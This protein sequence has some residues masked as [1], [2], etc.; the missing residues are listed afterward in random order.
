MSE[1]EEYAALRKAFRTDMRHQALP[2]A[3]L[4][5]LLPACVA[6]GPSPGTSQ[7][8][9]A[10]G[11]LLVRPAGTSDSDG[12][13]V[14]P[15][16][17]TGRLARPGL[18]EGSGPR[19]QD[20]DRR[21]P[22]VVTPYLE[23]GV[24]LEITGD[25]VRI[26]FDQPMARPG[27]IP[28]KSQDAKGTEPAAKGAK[29]AAAP[30]GRVAAPPGTLTIT[31]AV[32]GRVEWVDAYT[33]EFVAEEPMKIGER[34]EIALG[35][36]RSLA[37]GVPAAAWRT[38]AIPRAVVAGKILGYAPKAGAP[39]VV[40]MH[41]TG[42][43]V[44][45]RPEIAVLY[46]QP[47]DLVRAQSLVRIEGANGSRVPMML[48]RPPGPT[49]QGVPVDPRFVVVA[50][51]PPL[52]RGKT[53]SLRSMPAFEG[54]RGASTAFEIAP[55]L[56]VTS[57]ECP[58]ASDD[59]SVD[60][61]TVSTDGNGVDFDINNATP[62]T[63]KSEDLVKLVKVSPRVDHL[64]VYGGWWDGSAI[65]VRGAFEPSKRYEIT[66][67]GLV[68]RYGSR[69]AAP[70]RATLEKAPRDASVTMAS[71]VLLLDE[72]RTKR[73]E[74]TT[75]N[76]ELVE[77]AFWP[78][79]DEKLAAAVRSVQVGTRPLEAPHL[80]L[81]VTIA[82]R[83][84]E[85][86]TTPVDLSA[87]LDPG[88]RYIAAVRVMQ[89]LG[90]ADLPGKDERSPLALIVPG[91]AESLAVHVEK[92][93]ARTLVHVARLA[94][95]EAV[96]GAGIALLDAS[97]AD[98]STFA[99][100][101]DGLA[102]LPADASGWLAVTSGKARTLLHLGNADT[103]AR[104]LFPHLA[105][106]DEIAAGAPRGVLF[107]DRGIYR[108]GATVNLFASVRKPES[109]ALAPFADQR[110][111]AIAL[112][113]SGEEVFRAPLTTNDLGS[114]SASFALS[115]T[116]KL[117]RHRVVL[118][119][120]G[121]ERLADTIVQVAE[122][123]PPRFAVDVNTAGT[124]ARALRASVLARYLFGAPMSGATVKWTARREAAAIAEG[125]FAGSGMSFRPAREAWDEGPKAASWSRSGETTAGGDGVAKIEQALSLA[126][127]VGPQ[128]FVVEAEVTDASHR[129]IAGRAT[130]VVHSAERYG[131]VRVAKRWS[132][133]G[134]K[135][136]VQLAVVDREGRAV[137]GAPVSAVLKKVEYTEIARRDAGGE[138]TYEWSRRVTPAGQCA[139]KSAAAPVECSLI[140]PA[141]G[142]YEVSAEVDGRPGGTT[143]VWAW[144]DGGEDGPHLPGRGRALP[145]VTDRS[146]YAPGD[147]AKLF[148]TSPFA[149]ATAIVT[150]DAPGSEPRSVRIDGS[151]GVIEVPV[152]AADAPHVHAMVTLL[153]LR[154]SAAERAGKGSAV[155]DYRFGAVRLPVSVEDA[156]LV[157]EVTPSKPAYG[158]REQAEIAIRVKG[159]GGV[160]VIGAE[161]ALAVVDEGVLRLTGYHAP[162]PVAELRPGRALSAEVFD[163]RASLAD[164][165]AQSHVAGDGDDAAPSTRA[166]RRGE[167]GRSV[168][169]AREKMAETAFW[170][171]HLRTDGEGRAT[172]RFVL[173]D[174]LTDFRVMAV[175][176]DRE[177]R[178]AVTE[179][180]FHVTRPVL[181]S[182][183]LPRFVS[184]DDR[185]E[186]ATLVHNNTDEAALVKVGLEGRVRRLLVPAHGH[187]RVGFPV[188]VTCEEPDADDDEAGDDAQDPG[189]DAGENATF[190]DDDED[191]DVI[192]AC[193]T[194]QGGERAAIRLRF[195]VERHDGASLDA[196]ET[197]IPATFAGL[198]ETPRVEGAFV[199]ERTV[200]LQVPARVAGQ[201]GQDRVVVT[202]GA[203]LWPEL[204]E[205]VRYLLGY[206]HGCVEQT[207][208]STL[209][210]LAARDI[211]PQ[212]G[213]HHVDDAE[214]AKKIRAGLERLGTMRTAGGGLAYWPGGSE[215]N[216]YGTA[217]AMRALVLA[218]QAGIEPPA[219]LLDGMARYL[220]E[221]M[222]S[223][224]LE[225]EVRSAIAQSLAELGKLD[226]SAAD[227]LYERG[228]EQSVF[229]T[230]SLAIALSA[231]PGQQDR[232][233][234]LLDR[235]EAGIDEAGELR[236]QPRSSD[237]H[238]YGSPVRTKAQAAIALRRLRPTSPA[239]PPLVRALAQA[240]GS[241]TTQ[242]TAYSLIALAEEVRRLEPGASDATVLL[243][244]RPIEASR[245]LPRGGKQLEIPL[246]D[247][248]G[249][250]AT[251]SLSSASDRPIAFEVRAA[252]RRPSAADEAFRTARGPMVYRLYTDAKGGPVDLAKVRP[253]DVLRVALLARRPTSVDPARF[254]YVAITDRLPAGFEPVQQ[255][256]A[257]VAAQPE[258]DD[259]HP[260]AAW[261][262]YADERPSHLELHD[263]RV[264]VYFDGANGDDVAATYLVRATTPGRFAIPPATAELMYEPDSLGATE[265]SQVVVR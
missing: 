43:K 11:S 152:S 8:G 252:W 78:V 106:G 81:P 85:L 259:A 91:S 66:L 6:D 176:L 103:T 119:A 50:R 196:V 58:D 239:L 67:V 173:P 228:K 137:T 77:L 175:A 227:A 96:P 68:D 265:P 197:A 153:P 156:R 22:Q 158:P 102:F 161:V 257:T 258:I 189:D 245:D 220:A 72:E 145:I 225:P 60:G 219:D 30:K 37:G 94:T 188:L 65:R 74:V 214:L 7:N 242:A 38:G 131:G 132:A 13:L 229:G 222:L 263:D 264:N 14:F 115:P 201:G 251:L 208:S 4:A 200:A 167:T 160:P 151:A 33:L 118:E 111:V 52:E 100:R 211:A 128:R 112:G 246:A 9:D 180:S 75:M 177:G 147:T 12:A 244:G 73:F 69:L 2:I 88:R 26:R 63:M 19:A 215:P 133:P 164:L 129:A 212:I 136:A 250:S 169:K 143:S 182:P 248:A 56:E 3:L 34:H 51:T 126:G 48:S 18:G 95:G 256:L 238:Y 40:A 235:V 125:P 82:P 130:A 194:S 146:A 149:A 148:V 105:A 199:K 110:V 174:N 144:Q 35:D 249:K 261:L 1:G 234:A 195:D 55:P 23:E 49:F 107:T 121:D 71:G 64:S 138:L 157:L 122:V 70:V 104:K 25:R 101:A 204:G 159:A 183:A 179:T 226:A 83:E 59:C 108:P 41:P 31:P 76:A 207:T 224:Q 187:V 184:L 192:R 170:D 47:V 10:P 165:V 113:P 90:D 243:D 236:E 193:P 92:A 255:D 28:A 221:Q 134:E 217:Y 231:L 150:T 190:A 54:D 124:D 178:G 206:P 262:R 44:G 205:R 223:P 191:D 98:G 172:A 141:A 97:G 116:A 86:T 17:D 99:T 155:A 46:D 45:P 36:V 61:T 135:L 87:V 241:Y 89:A 42:G 29:G 114:V 210:L 5:V 39:R 253:G 181:L 213:L 15:P 186:A 20:Q 171:P 117:G 123:E 162:D 21:A 84:N 127:T 139:A 185:F 93:V 27:D 154:P 218:K 168:T 140:L 260:L 233:A 57:V 254:G 198:D 240:T 120:A 80:T 203:H 247:L 79:D 32:R 109:G 53:F 237:F 230:A 142:D 209:P 202:L 163:T 62:A 24:P 16:P 166:G 232:V 216:T